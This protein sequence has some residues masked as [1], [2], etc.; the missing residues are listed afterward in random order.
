[1]EIQS[2][3]DLPEIEY[4]DAAKLQVMDT[5]EDRAPNLTI[6]GDRSHFEIKVRHAFPRTHPA[7]FI[8][9]YDR[10]DD[11][12]G[13]LRNLKELDRASRKLLERELDHRY[14]SP[15]ITEI[16]S[17]REEYGI[18]L[19]DVETNRGPTKFGVR[20]V[21]ENVKELEPGRIRIIDVHD[22]VYEIPDIA[23]LDTDSLARIREIV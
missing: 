9:L 13:M 4:L 22:S 5:G 11:E 10:G 17:I 15:R 19:F 12:I 7:E 18:T 2:L 6:E 20:S 1:M 16:R 23:R 21:R 14:F 3:S 8:V